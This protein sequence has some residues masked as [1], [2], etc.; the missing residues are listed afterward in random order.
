MNQAEAIEFFDHRTGVD[1]RRGPRR[2]DDPVAFYQREAADATRIKIPPE[3]IG[4]TL[5]ITAL[6]WAASALTDRYWAEV[7]KYRANEGAAVYAIGITNWAAAINAMSEA[8]RR[9]IK[10]DD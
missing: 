5:S 8:K 9:W 7:E 6:T 1:R 4:V 2:A 10:G 3:D